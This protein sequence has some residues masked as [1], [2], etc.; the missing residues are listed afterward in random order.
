MC[1]TLNNTKGAKTGHF[2]MH[3]LAM[4]NEFKKLNALLLL[5]MLL[6]W[7]LLHFNT[8]SISVLTI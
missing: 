8:A 3:L 2:L 4:N 7:F 5:D 1:S 6:L